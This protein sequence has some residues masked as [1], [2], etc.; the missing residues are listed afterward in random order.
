MM[1]AF[2][3]FRM[4]T[5]LIVEDDLDIH[6]PVRATLEQAGYETLSA[7][8]L[9]DAR[10]IIASDA[11]LD[12]VFTDVCLGHD[13]D[14]G[15]EVGKAVTI[16]RYGTPVMYTSGNELTPRLKEY[17]D[18]SGPFFAKPYDVGEILSRMAQLI[19]H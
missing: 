10:A 6:G 19:K 13:R 2:G 9:N 7:Y 12:L 14:G 18:S 8:S 3:G 16:A 11:E 4:A 15:V 1:G 5:V 17:I